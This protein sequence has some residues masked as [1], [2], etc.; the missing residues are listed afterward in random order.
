MSF[1]T[2]RLLVYQNAYVIRLGHILCDDYDNTWTFLGDDQFYALAKDY[3]HAHPSDTPNARFF[4]DK[5]PEFLEGQP[6][7]KEHPAVPDLA[8]LER[9]LRDAFDASD[10][11]V[12]ASEDLAKLGGEN[13]EEA[14][15]HLHPSV[16]VMR[17]A[18]NG[19]DVFC[20][21]RDEQTPPAP[22]RK[23]PGQWVAVWRR[24]MICRHVV[25]ADEE[26][27]LLDLARQG[28]T[29]AQLCEASALF[30]DPDNTALRMA[31]YMQQWIANHMLTGITVDAG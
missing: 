21:L 24:E 8:R 10:D 1:L 15:F 27:T 29:F 25:L 30:G 14:V 26:G 16:A 28:Y 6:V 17:L 7:G 2:K 4:T 18:S 19:Y 23:D 5:F 12:I 20:A 11:P 3:I 31:G 13:F 22:V 9:A